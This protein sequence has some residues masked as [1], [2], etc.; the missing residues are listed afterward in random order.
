MPGILYIVATPIGNLSDITPRAAHVFST[1]DFIAAEDTRV[2]AK[3]LHHL[4][5]KKPLV[6]YH[7]HNI[8][9]R[10]EGILERIALGESCALC[11][12]AGTPAISDPGE[13][14]VQQAMDRGITVVPISGPCAAITAL[15]ASGQVTGRFCF[16]GFLS[17][18]P[19]SRRDHLDALVNE[20]RTMIFYEAPH[21]LKKTLQDL[22]DTFGPNRSITLARELTKIHEEILKTTLGEANEL[23]AQREPKGE[24]VLVVAGAEKKEVSPAL[25]LSQ[26]AE[27]VRLLQAQGL[28]LREAS[29]QIAAETG[30]RKSELYKFA[31]DLDKEPLT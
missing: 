21:K 30:F 12:D 24:Y 7:Q 13:V 4:G 11:A 3:L 27:K 15:C 16:E 22:A 31:L 6:S 17:T 5:I 23:Y 26:A 25:S 2:T 19:K 9:E 10:G 28:P 29:R 1:V 20:Y 14:L 18:A 8:R